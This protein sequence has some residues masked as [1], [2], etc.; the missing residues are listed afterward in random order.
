MMG[1]GRVLAEKW[2][3]S[4]EPG[5]SQMDRPNRDEVELGVWSCDEGFDRIRALVWDD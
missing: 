1:D 3:G 5:F 2:V 4:A